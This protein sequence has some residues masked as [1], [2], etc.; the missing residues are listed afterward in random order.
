[1]KTK[2]KF[3]DKNVI[4]VVSNIKRFINCDSAKILY[5]FRN[6]IIIKLVVSKLI[7]CFF[8]KKISIK[9]KVLIK[10]FKNIKL[11]CSFH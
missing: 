2:K 10:S 11:D 5:K 9:I 7:T 3:I 4:N 6:F 1:M 8:N